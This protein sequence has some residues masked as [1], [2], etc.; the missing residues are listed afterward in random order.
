MHKNLEEIVLDLRNLQENFQMTA[1]HM[2][3]HRW[4]HELP[5]KVAFTS[6]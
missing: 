4:Y 3:Y 2:G 5:K 1:D 6:V